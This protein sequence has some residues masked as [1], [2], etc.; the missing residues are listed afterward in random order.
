MPIR[1]AANAILK[2]IMA[3]RAIGAEIVISGKLQQQRAKS[4]K[5]RAGYILSTGQPK[6]DFIDTSYRHVFFKQGIMGVKV[7]IFLPYDEHGKFG[8]IRFQVPDKV[9]INEP[10]HIEPEEEIRVASQ[11]AE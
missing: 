9:K 1:T 5:Y 11:Q 2:Q 4:M 8:G 6:I 7:K 10:K 3:D